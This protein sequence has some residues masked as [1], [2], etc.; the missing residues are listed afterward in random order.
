MSDMFWVHEAHVTPTFYS[1]I[2]NNDDKTKLL[3][4]ENRLVVAI[5]EGDGRMGEVG[6]GKK[7]RMSDILVQMMVTWVY[8]YVQM[9]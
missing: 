3:D 2:L 4:T 6:E 9:Y 7:I 8:T 1:I 5:G